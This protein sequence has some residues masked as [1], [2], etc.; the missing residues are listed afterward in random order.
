MLEIRVLR[1][2]NWVHVESCHHLIRVFVV[3]QSLLVRLVISWHIPHRLSQTYSS[4]EAKILTILLSELSL[5]HVLHEKRT[6]SF[7]GV[8]ALLSQK[9][10]GIRFLNKSL[11]ILLYTFLL[12]QWLRHE[13]KS[14]FFRT[15]D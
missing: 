12:T 13:R 5:R 9:N 1:G 15:S 3:Q 2:R 11:E 6:Q 8:S 7:V 14:E 10:F 4:C